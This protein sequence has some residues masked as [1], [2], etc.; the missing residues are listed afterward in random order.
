MFIDLRKAFDTVDTNRLVRKLQRLGLSRDASNLMLSYLQNRQTAT[1]FGSY[2]S[3][4]RNLK[5]GV[6]GTAS[7]HHLH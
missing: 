5:V 4:F 3:C 6:A 7:F 1:T 2:T